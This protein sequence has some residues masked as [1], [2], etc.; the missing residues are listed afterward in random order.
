MYVYKIELMP[1]PD[2]THITG[3]KTNIRRTITPFIIK[4][5]IKTTF[6]YIYGY[7]ISIYGKI[8]ACHS[9]ENNENVFVRQIL[10][11]EVDTNL[12]KK[13]FILSN[14]RY[15]RKKQNTSFN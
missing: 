7:L 8:D 11:A 9:I 4:L 15:V 3:A 10:E 12:K 5:T 13:I 2:N 1:M 6:L 14:Q